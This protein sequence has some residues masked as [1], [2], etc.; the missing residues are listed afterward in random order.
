MLRRWV[1]EPTGA[2]I[3][4]SEDKDTVKT[5]KRGCNMTRAKIAYDYQVL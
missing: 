1:G 5:V 4:V 3:G 2:G